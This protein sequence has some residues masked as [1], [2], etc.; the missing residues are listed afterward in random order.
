M[1]RLSGENKKK[2]YDFLIN[3]CCL[4]IVIFCSYFVILVIV[5]GLVDKR[6]G[7]S[8]PEVVG[9]NPGSVIF[10]FFFFF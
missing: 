10:F 6:A 7:F 2:S 8:N 9:S 1:R 3:N 4:N 5:F